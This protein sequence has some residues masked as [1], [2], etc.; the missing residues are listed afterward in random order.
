M[1]G[2][3]WQQKYDSSLAVILHLTRGRLRRTKMWNDKACP[4]D[5][6]PPARFHLLKVPQLSQT[7]PPT[8]DQVVKHMR[9]FSFKPPLRLNTRHCLF[10]REFSNIMGIWSQKIVLWEILPAWKSINR[11]MKYWLWANRLIDMSGIVVFGIKLNIC[12]MKFELSGSKEWTIST[13]I[14]SWTPNHNYGWQAMNE[15]FKDFFS[16]KKSH[17][18]ICVC[19]HAHV[20]RH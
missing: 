18:F 16:F 11:N 17:L 7:S 13:I 2:T 9:H 8:G 20:H 19:A 10:F 15:P 14:S 1:K 3:A 12:K 5:A 4:S 6:L